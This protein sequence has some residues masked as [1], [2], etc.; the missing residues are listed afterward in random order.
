M[1]PRVLGRKLFGASS[2]GAGALIA[3]LSTG[4]PVLAQTH[5]DDVVP[6]N[7]DDDAKF[8][9]Q[10]KDIEKNL[11]DFLLIDEDKKIH[12]RKEFQ[13]GLP[14][15]VDAKQAERM[16]QMFVKIGDDG[17]LHVRDAEQLR[18]FLPQIENFFKQ[19][20]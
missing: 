14:G 16:L 9:K 13:E 17:K 19:G 7:N 11:N 4:R 8:E 12:I 2:I 5:D 6:V 20:G 3:L 1:G 15:G 18:P 10:V